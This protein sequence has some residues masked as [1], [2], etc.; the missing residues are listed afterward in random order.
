MR[1]NVFLADPLDAVKLND[2]PAVILVKLQRLFGEV[3]STAN[4]AIRQA[5]ARK[6][7]DKQEPP[8]TLQVS[9]SPTKPSPS[10]TDILIYFVPIQLSIVKKF[11]AKATDPLLSS[12]WGLTAFKERSGNKIAEAA[13]EVHAKTLDA[14]VL[15]P[16]AFHESMH[17][18]LVIDGRLH[19]QGGLA[20]GTVDEKTP[21]TVANKS[22][23]AGALTNKVKQWTDGFDILMSAKHRRDAN[24]PLWYLI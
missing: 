18:K 14:G 15:A 12:H 10:D 3:I 11:D 20:A 16:L 9:W 5:N 19:T 6:P 7:A 4:E 21:L 22:A 1:L 17:N 24:D 13:S 23:M 8:H 2:T